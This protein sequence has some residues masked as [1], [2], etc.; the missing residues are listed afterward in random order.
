MKERK[1]KKDN[2]LIQQ[3][4]LSIILIFFTPDKFQTDSFGLLQL[5]ASFPQ[6]A[7]NRYLKTVATT[8]NLYIEASSRTKAIVYGKAAFQ[9]IK[10]TYIVIINWVKHNTS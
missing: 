3:K 7:D 1:H 9:M 4:L 10:Q 2:I 6:L 5:T 8:V